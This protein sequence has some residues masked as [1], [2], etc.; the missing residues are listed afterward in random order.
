MKQ[1]MIKAGVLLFGLMVLF[2]VISRA[3]YNM[4][5]AEVSAE[6]PEPQTFT[7]DVSAQGVVT[8][9][10]EIAVSTAESVR[11]K[12]VHV[13]AGQ[14]VEAGEVLYELDLQDL[15]EKMREKQL[16]LQSLDLQIRGTAESEAAA[17][18]SRQLSRSQAQEDYNRIAAR[19]N[20]AVDAALNELRQA[21]EQYQNVT[22]GQAG[23]REPAS[24][25]AD[26]VQAGI[27]EPAPDQVNSS[28][29]GGGATTSDERN[30]GQP[31][32]DQSSSWQAADQLRAAVQEKQAAYDQAVRNREDSLYNA[33][34]SVDSANL[35]AAKSYSVEQSQILR[36]QKEEE[37]AK[38]QALLDVQ[39]RVA[40]PVKGM[41][42]EVSVK[43]GSASGSGGDILLSDISG[44][45]S[46]TVTFPEELREYVREGAQAVVSAAD[47]GSGQPGMPGAGSQGAAGS[48]NQAGKH[49]VSDRVTIRSIADNSMTG[50][51]M[52]GN[53]GAG[54]D[55]NGAGSMPEAASGG[56]FT[57]T[58]DLQPDH[59]TA[60]E[61]AMLKVE[62][63]PD[64]YDTCI[65]LGALHLREKDQ[66]YVNVAEKRSTILG[67]EWV[68]RQVDVDLLE[69][70]EK[71]AAVEG[72]SSEQEIV[73]ESSR[74]L[75]E[76][77]RVKMKD[78]G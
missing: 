66:Y 45:A 13:M 61:K 15:T 44:G 16:E 36:G 68:I 22:A 3:A 7:P 20:E 56:S 72:I 18:Q 50:N 23:I 27:G 35:E 10:Q 6:K 26:S 52:T 29:T 12:T 76:G 8:G 71:F 4:S 54:M 40:A 62:I 9:S 73:A 75:E 43:A 58:V 64:N 74:T 31:E 5:I 2:T 57:V 1:R 14:A 77:S 24:G 19:E 38:L 41:V 60:G 34:K 17:E 70:N 42:T 11:V 67:E 33:Q 63:P 51:P 37:I 32:L 78:E 65:P 53:E 47:S 59:F 39:G 49:A 25:Q 30:P 55:T 46:L 69:K 21:Q 48:E 28:Q